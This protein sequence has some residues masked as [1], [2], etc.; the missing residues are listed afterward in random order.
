MFLHFVQLRLYGHGHEVEEE[1]GDEDEEE[2]EITLSTFNRWHCIALV[3][4]NKQVH[5][6]GSITRMIDEKTNRIENQRKIK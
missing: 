6:N 3:P 1:E 5:A 4:M 2:K